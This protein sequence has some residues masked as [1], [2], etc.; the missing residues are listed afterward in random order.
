MHTQRTPSAST[1]RVRRGL[2]DT[3]P[4]EINLPHSWG[5]TQV[6]GPLEPCPAALPWWAPHSQQ[7]HCQCPPPAC[8]P[9]R[10]LLDSVSLPPHPQGWAVLP[11]SLHSPAQPC[12]ALH[13]H[14]MQKHQTQHNPTF[15]AVILDT[16]SWA[17]H[18]SHC[19]IHGHGVRGFAQPCNLA[20]KHTQSL[21]LGTR[22]TVDTCHIYMCCN[23]QAHARGLLTRLH[24]TAGPGP[25][26]GLAGTRFGLV[27]TYQARGRGAQCLEGQE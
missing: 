7:P 24:C 12:T 1:A 2:R 21:C 27:R 3:V 25:A 19:H 5:L 4:T 26:R 15:W 6:Q 16:H 23:T 14:T 18:V 11:W 22:T 10:L 13:S 8:P 20:R 17:P 9:T